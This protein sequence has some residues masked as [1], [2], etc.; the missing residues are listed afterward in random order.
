MSTIE[1]MRL[2]ECKVGRMSNSCG[3]IA[4]SGEIQT[5]SNGDGNVVSAAIIM[6][7]NSNDTLASQPAFYNNG[8][9]NIARTRKRDKNSKTGYGGRLCVR[10]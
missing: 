9:I 7:S 5:Q 6:K 10:I 8:K 4:R 1:Y 2:F 3:V